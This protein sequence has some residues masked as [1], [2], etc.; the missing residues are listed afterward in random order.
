MRIA[1]DIPASRIAD[2]MIGAIEGNAMTRSWCNGVFWKTFEAE[3]PPGNWYAEP[4]MY[5]GEFQVEVHEIVDESKEAEGDNIRRHLC[6]RAAF[7]KGLTIMAER[8]GDH[9][10]DLLKENDDNITQD[11]FL[12]CVAL[13]E[14]VYG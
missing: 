13:G 5:A 6:D 4:A 11:V 9:F 2:L 14:V 8:Y 3:P 7:E 1:L 12:Q 10:G